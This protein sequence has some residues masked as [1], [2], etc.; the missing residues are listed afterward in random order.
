[1]RRYTDEELLTISEIQHFCFCP[2][3]WQLITLEQAWQDNHLTASGQLLHRRVD[4]PELSDRV[5]EVITLRR[6][7][8]VS[9]TL[10]LQGLSDAVELTP[11]EDP[12]AKPFVHPAYPGRWRATPVE[13]KRGRP[14]RHSA[15]KLQLCAQTIAL[16]EMY[17]I[18]IPVAFLYY[19]ETRHRLPV[20]I[21]EALRS[22]CRA[23]AREMHEAF[24]RRSAIPPHYSAR[25]RSCSLFDDCLPRIAGHRSAKAYLK[26]NGL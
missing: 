2:R 1:M 7:P 14:K 5:G 19:G 4:R 15:D 22:E 13:Y 11:L 8:L 9:Y 26:H 6:V 25:C 23:T 3:Q 24:A 21:D 17:D 12:D 16:E 18:I 10:G 20:T